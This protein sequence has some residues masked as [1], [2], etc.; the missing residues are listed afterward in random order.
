MLL[1]ETNTVYNLYESGELD[2]AILTG[3]FKQNRDNPDYEA[4]ERSKSIPLR[5]NQKNEKT[6][7]FCN[8]N[9]RKALAY[10]LDKKI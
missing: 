5:L 10:A 4:I 8:E 1:K 9:V 3:D 2:V 7:H 6:I